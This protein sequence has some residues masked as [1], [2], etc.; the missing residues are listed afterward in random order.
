MTAPA[1]VRR[2]EHG[3]P[4][5]AK[6]P[7]SD[8]RPPNRRHRG[9][10]PVSVEHRRAGS[11]VSVERRWAIGACLAA[12]DQ[13]PVLRRVAPLAAVWLTAVAATAGLAPHLAVRGVEPDVLLVT[14]VAVAVG[15]G[16]RAGA[17]FGFAAGLGAD[18]FLATPLGTSALA[19][20]LVGHV[21]GRS[22]RPRPPASAALCSP[23]STCFA[24]RTGRRHV[25]AAG[26]VRSAAAALY[27]APPVRRRR[28]SAAHRAALRRSMTLA[29]LAVVAGR[30]GAGMVATALGGIPLPTT[31]ALLHIVGAAILSAPL[32]IPSVAAS[33]RL[34][35]VR[36]ARR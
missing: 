23:T 25:A 29:F 20:T 17:A 8:G 31:A 11:S 16:A 28:R 30:V 3:T 35:H 13:L 36:G 19:Y 9:D 27:N 32:G 22:R 1:V 5:A 6:P 24:C 7:A 21:V 26:G 12:R 2:L 34:G 14:A 15:R 10:H 18:L 33:R 4:A